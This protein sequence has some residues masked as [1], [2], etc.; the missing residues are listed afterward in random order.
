MAPSQKPTPIFP[1][2]GKSESEPEG[3]AELANQHEDFREAQ[4]AQQQN[5]QD[6]VSRRVPPSLL[7]P[8]R[9]SLAPLEKRSLEHQMKFISES[10]HCQGWRDYCQQLASGDRSA[11]DGFD[12]HLL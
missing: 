7:I 1:R 8:K 3:H 2:K 12:S 5:D 11:K 9:T 10:F 6:I 4:Y